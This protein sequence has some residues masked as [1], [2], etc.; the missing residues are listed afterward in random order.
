MVA[1][2][3]DSEDSRLRVSWQDFPC[4]VLLFDAGL[5]STVAGN[6]IFG[7]VVNDLATVPGGAVGDQFGDDRAA[8][9]L[10]IRTESDLLSYLPVPLIDILPIQLKLVDALVS[11]LFQN[12]RAEKFEVWSPPMFKAQTSYSETPRSRRGSVDPPRLRRGSPASRRPWS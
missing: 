10:E 3:Y 5:G 8:G 4:L 9:I 12:R 1:V 2:S 6:V 7:D 11:A